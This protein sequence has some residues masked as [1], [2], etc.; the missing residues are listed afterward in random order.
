[1]DGYKTMIELPDI[2]DKVIMVLD[3]TP[4]E[5]TETTTFND[6]KRW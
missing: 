5:C 4:Q 3:G 2:V 1:M 6:G